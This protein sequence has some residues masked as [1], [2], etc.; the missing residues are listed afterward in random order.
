MLDAT[1][2]AAV[3]ANSLYVPDPACQSADQ[4]NVDHLKIQKSDGDCL[5]NST[6]RFDI[7]NSD[8]SFQ[9]VWQQKH[10]CCE[11]HGGYKTLYVG[12]GGL[13]L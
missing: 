6:Q 12:S 5:V 1:L 11:D 10:E 7:F 4:Q 9:D 3:G 2:V 8:H 13:G